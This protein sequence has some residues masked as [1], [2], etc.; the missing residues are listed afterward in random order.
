M[1]PLFADCRDKWSP[2]HPFFRHADAQH[3]VAVR[4]GRD[5][6]RIAAA[7]DREQ[8]RVHGDRT[9]LFGWFECERR[10]ETAHALLD[11]APAWLRKRAR[12]RVR[13]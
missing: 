8:D 6:G 12:D 5:V 3:F 2:E 13:F 7:V 11:A 1:V 9:G 4:E 10:P